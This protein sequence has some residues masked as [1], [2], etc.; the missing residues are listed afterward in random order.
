M[1]RSW[2]S[3]RISAGITCRYGFVVIIY[4]ILQ[5]FL[6]TKDVLPPEREAVAARIGSSFKNM[7]M[8][9]NQNSLSMTHAIF[10]QSL[11]NG[12]MTKEIK[13]QRYTTQKAPFQH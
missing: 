4:S 5:I 13:L 9:I 6:P 8:R 2:E 10:P 12:I 3:A 7:R 1:S 11:N